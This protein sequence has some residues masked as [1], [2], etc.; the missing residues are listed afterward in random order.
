M[1]TKL[2]ALEAG[3]GVCTIVSTYVVISLTWYYCKS[4]CSTDRPRSRHAPNFTQGSGRTTHQVRYGQSLHCVSNGRTQLS[5]TGVNGRLGYGGRAVSVNHSANVAVTTNHSVALHRLCLSS[6]WLVLAHHAMEHI[7]LAFALS[8]LYAWVSCEILI[9]LQIV[10]YL[11]PLSLQYIF[12]WLRQRV[13][14]LS[15][16][17]THKSWTCSLWL[18]WI[19]IAIFFLSEVGSVGLFMINEKYERNFTNNGTENGTM[20]CTRVP[21][22]LLPDYLP[23]VVTGILAFLS[24]IIFLSLYIQPLCCKAE[25]INVAEMTM[26]RHHSSS[27]FSR[28]KRVFVASGILAATDLLALACC[29][30]SED[31]YISLVILE[32][33][34]LINQVSLVAS[35]WTWKARLFPLWAAR[36][37]EE[38]G[39]QNE[40]LKLQIPSV[41]N[42]ISSSRSHMSSTSTIQE[43]CTE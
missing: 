25:A 4:H 26:N 42:G 18:G 39:L 32:C 3:V 12:L 22:N 20:S 24:Q 37:R 34:L 11:L 43:V 35:Y 36:F 31:L 13:L 23:W 21:T 19:F 8:N 27:F 40:T 5:C 17:L 16:V 10:F 28:V 9:R 14:C 30:I 1:D 7:V 15:P 41:S 2:I 29:T 6:A 33:N 38:N